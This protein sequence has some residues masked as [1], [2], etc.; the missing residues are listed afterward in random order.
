[1]GTGYWLLKDRQ[2]IKKKAYFLLSLPFIG[3]VLASGF[4]YFIPSIYGDCDFYN[5]PDTLNAGIKTFNGKTY[6]IQVCGVGGNGQDGADDELELQV[7]SLEGELLAKRH[8]SVNWHASSA[9]HEPLQ[10][11]DNSI[12]YNPANQDEGKISIPPTKLDWIF[13][14]IPFFN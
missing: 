5:D 3:Y 13:A 6:K 4:V 7:F 8:Y 1:M 11:T 10:Y 9:S 12:T 14:R 2:T